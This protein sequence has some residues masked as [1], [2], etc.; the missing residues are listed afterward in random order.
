MCSEC[1]HITV[2]N[3]PCQ[4]DLEQLFPIYNELKDKTQ[5]RMNIVICSS[6]GSAIACYEVVR[7]F[8]TNLVCADTM[9]RIAWHREQLQTI[10]VAFH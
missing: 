2:P 9:A 4:A 8:S 3:D 7:T 1:K 6:I 5:E 10:C